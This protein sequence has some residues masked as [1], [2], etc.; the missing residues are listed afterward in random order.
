MQN[1]KILDVVI[2]FKKIEIIEQE[3]EKSQKKEDKSIYSTIKMVLLIF[4]SLNIQKVAQST[5][6]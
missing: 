2:R 6:K 3:I 5:Y 1:I 4:N